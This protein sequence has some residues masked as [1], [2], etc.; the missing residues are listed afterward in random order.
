MIPQAETTTVTC[1]QMIELK[2]AHATETCEVE[3]A[4]DIALA[5]AAVLG[6]EINGQIVRCELFPLLDILNRQHP[7]IALPFMP[8]VHHVG[9]ARMI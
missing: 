3:A 4:Q 8:C 7:Y 1:D 5:T 6:P 2:T 9:R